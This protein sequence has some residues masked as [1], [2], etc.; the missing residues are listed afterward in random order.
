M[1]AGI[2][3]PPLRLSQRSSARRRP[4]EDC[5]MGK[6]MAKANVIWG[7]QHAVSLASFS[8]AQMA[9]IID[10][11]QKNIE[12]K[13]PINHSAAQPALLK[14]KANP[15][16]KNGYVKVGVIGTDLVLRCM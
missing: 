14:A 12:P 11:I 7:E 1:P 8:S 2:N 15:K 16:M 9:Q 5:A 3:S 10:L 6:T 4:Q 13:V